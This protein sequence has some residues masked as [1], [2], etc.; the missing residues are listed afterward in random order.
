MENHENANYVWIS[1]FQTFIAISIN[2][3]LILAYI[4][5]YVKISNEGTAGISSWFILWT[6]IF[7]SSQFGSHLSNRHERK[8][9]ELIRSGSLEGVGVFDTFLGLFQAGSQWLANMILFIIFVINRTKLTDETTTSDLGKLP[10]SISS[11]ALIVV[12][13]IHAVVCI[14]L[15]LAIFLAVDPHDFRAFQSRAR[16]SPRLHYVYHIN[17][18]HDHHNWSRKLSICSPNSNHPH[19]QG[20]RK[21]Q[22]PVSCTAACSDT[23]FGGSPDLAS[24]QGE[25]STTFRTDVEAN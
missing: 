2:F 6:C 8:P 23:C 13:V 1:L 7:S 12:V 10:P 20:L 4:P 22:Y 18:L 21:Y 16:M 15:G 3:C 9:L 19:S 24:A 11:T 5:Q 14:S 25:F 17:H